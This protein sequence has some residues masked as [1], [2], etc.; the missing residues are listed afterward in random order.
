MEMNTRLCITAF[1]AL[2]FR[3]SNENGMVRD[4]GVEDSTNTAPPG[5]GVIH[6]PYSIR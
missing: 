4:S 5:D 6:P 2:N 1:I 3:R